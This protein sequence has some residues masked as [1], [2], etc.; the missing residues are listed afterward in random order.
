MLR[1]SMQHVCLNGLAVRAK[2]TSRLCVV[3]LMVTVWTAAAAAGGTVL[4]RP[5]VTIRVFDNVGLPRRT[6]RQAA[7]VAQ[8]IFRRAGVETDWLCMP[9][10]S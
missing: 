7:L 9:P 1:N 4:Q 8:K 3:G 10:E 6:L 2:E 5:P